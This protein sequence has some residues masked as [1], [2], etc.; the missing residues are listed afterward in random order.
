M[1]L[2]KIELN[3][4]NHGFKGFTSQMYLEIPYTGPKTSTSGVSLIVSIMGEGCERF[5]ASVDRVSLKIIR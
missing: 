3:K 1:P 4:T 5:M 2:H